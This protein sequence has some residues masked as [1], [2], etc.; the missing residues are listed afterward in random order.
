MNFLES[1]FVCKFFNEVKGTKTLREKEEFLYWL[2]LAKPIVHLPV[3]APATDPGNREKL[4]HLP[5]STIFTQN[6]TN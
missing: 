1:L 3:L 5:F 4:K 6:P 2:Q